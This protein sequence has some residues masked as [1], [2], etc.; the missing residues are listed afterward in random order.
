MLYSLH[1]PSCLQKEYG[2]QAKGGRCRLVVAGR[3]THQADRRAGRQT[4]RQA[5][6]QTDRQAGRKI[7]R[8]AGRQKDKKTDLNE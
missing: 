1:R 2:R 5:G 4:D 6:K 7:D 3:Q 8:Q